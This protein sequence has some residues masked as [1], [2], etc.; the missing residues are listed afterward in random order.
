MYEL[1]VYRVYDKRKE[2]TFESSMVNRK[3]KG[4]FKLHFETLSQVAKWVI[5]SVNTSL[6]VKSD[7]LTRREHKILHK[8]LLSMEVRRYHDEI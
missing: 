4:S 8:K 7:N 5:D 1:E 3:A 6:M 2:H